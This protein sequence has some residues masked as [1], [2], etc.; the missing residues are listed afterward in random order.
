MLYYLVRE[1]LGGRHYAYENTLFRGTCAALMCFV[2]T[3]LCLPWVI[4]QLIKLKLGD[5]PEFDHASLNELTRE[6]ELH[7]SERDRAVRCF[8]CGHRCFIPEG[9]PGICKVRYNDGGS[10]KVPWGYVGALQCDPVEKKPFFHTLPGVDA[11]SFGMLGC[12]YHCGYCQNWITSQALRDPLAVATPERMT[13]DDLAE[14][15]V[16]RGA[17]IMASTYNEP[18]IT[19]E[20]AV[21]VFRAAARRG[22]LC[23]YVSNGNGTEE[24]RGQPAKERLHVFEVP[25]V[26]AALDKHAGP[27]IAA[28]HDA[29][30]ES[31]E[32]AQPVGLDPA[33]SVA[34]IDQR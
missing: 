25:K 11:L 33:V 18:L 6:G 3:L 12:D 14:M 16:R 1:L 9:R 28:D 29:V 32:Q 17:R 5:R 23:A 8:A 10:L 13:P 21:A 27:D 31:F 2:L 19:S 26:V 20:W 4:R 15:A 7:R 22:L 24:V 34:D 30:G